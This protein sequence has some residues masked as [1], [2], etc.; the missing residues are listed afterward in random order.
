MHYTYLFIIAL[1]G[2]ALW[3]VLYR[4]AAAEIATK[5]PKAV[6]P[7][8]PPRAAQVVP[9]VPTL[10]EELEAWAVKTAAALAGQNIPPVLIVEVIEQIR[11]H[12]ESTPN[13]L[14]TKQLSERIDLTA[15]TVAAS[16]RFR[17]QT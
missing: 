3:L 13:R 16:G 6:E 10:E 11:V 1:G 15:L 12:A 4:A 9:L 8:K 2:V 14:V 7:K 17:G 5:Y